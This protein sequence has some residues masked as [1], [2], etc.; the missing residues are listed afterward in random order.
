MRKAEGGGRKDEQ[1]EEEEEEEDEEEEEA[2]GGGRNRKIK[3]LQLEGWGTNNERA[4]WTLNKFWQLELS[5]IVWG[6]MGF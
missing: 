3:P 1:E 2:G 4:M 6:V 5:R